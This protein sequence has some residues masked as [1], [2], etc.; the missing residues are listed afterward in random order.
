MSICKYCDEEIFWKQSKM[1][2]WYAVD[3][4]SNPRYFHSKSCSGR[5]QDFPYQRI[6]DNPST[7]DLGRPSGVD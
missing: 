1:G 6:N 7:L 4:A 3:D 5:D 2:K